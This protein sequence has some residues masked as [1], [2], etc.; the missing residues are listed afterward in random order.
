MLGR[1]SLQT[2]VQSWTEGGLCQGRTET[3]GPGLAREET[4]AWRTLVWFGV[5]RH[6]DG[7]LAKGPETRRRPV[8]VSGPAAGQLG[9]AWQPSRR[10]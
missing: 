10:A 9:R 8:S 3:C 5:V 7:T 6:G 1:N 4:K 2:R